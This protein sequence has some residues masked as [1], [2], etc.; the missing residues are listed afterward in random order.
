MVLSLSDCFHSRT[1]NDSQF[2]F[3]RN[4]GRT[5]GEAK[6]F[7]KR[8]RDIIKQL[9]NGSIAKGR[10]QSGLCVSFTLRSE[11]TRIFCLFLSIF[12]DLSAGWPLLPHSRHDKSP[13][14]WRQIVDVA[15]FHRK[16]VTNWRECSQFYRCFVNVGV[17]SCS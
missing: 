6:T 4:R 3:S 12:T 11:F 2:H 17:R 16:I 7:D 8:R 15:Q 14:Q 13:S 10:R 5:R 1:V 9:M